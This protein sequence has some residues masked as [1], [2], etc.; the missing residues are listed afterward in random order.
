MNKKLTIEIDGSG[1]AFDGDSDL[2][3]GSEWSV[4]SASEFS[5]ILRQAA[6]AIEGDGAYPDEHSLRDINGNVCG[7]LSIEVIG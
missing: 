4:G 6:N 5:R 7:N 1:A 2:D 3:Y